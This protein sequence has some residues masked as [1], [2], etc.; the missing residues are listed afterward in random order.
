MP[1]QQ[2]VASSAPAGTALEVTAAVSG[3]ELT[4]TVRD[5]GPGLTPET[6]TRVFEKFYRA[7]G[8]RAGGTGLG[9]PIARGLLRAMKG[10]ITAATHPEGGALFKLHLPVQLHQP[11]A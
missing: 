2:P 6:A 9:L 1:V 10:D 11:A 8:S 4:L 3:G 5:H 7:P